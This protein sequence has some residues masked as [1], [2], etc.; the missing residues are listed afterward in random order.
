MCLT[1]HVLATTHSPL[2]LAWLTPEDYETTFLCKRDEETGE[3]K[4]LPL[5]R[6]PN[7]SEVIGKQPI[8]DLFAEG[9]M[10]AAV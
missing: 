6:L 7:F 1:L 10:E 2:L 8:T 3:A 5:T 4:I 9:W